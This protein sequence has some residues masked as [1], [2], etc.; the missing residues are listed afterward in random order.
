MDTYSSTF[1]K[2]FVY[3][4]KRR[5]PRTRV[6]ANLVYNEFVSDRHHTHMNATM[7]ESLTQFIKHLGRSG[8]AVVED[9]PKGWYITYK[10]PDA[11]AE[12]EAQLKKAKLDLDDEE[13]NIKF[14][15]KQIGLAKKN[16]HTEE[17]VEKPAE[18]EKEKEKEKQEPP[19]PVKIAFG[20]ENVNK[21]SVKSSSSLVEKPSQAVNALVEFGLD[22]ELT[23]KNKTSKKST[24]EVIM[25]AEEHKKELLNRK[26]YWL[27][28]NIVVKI[29]NSALGDGKYYKKKGLVTKVVDLFV[30]EIQMLEFP[31]IIRLDQSQLETVIPPIGGRVLIVNGAYRGE[32]AS[33][34][35]L[36]VDSFCANLKVDSGLHYGRLLSGIQ[37]EDFS[38]F[39]A[40]T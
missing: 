18:K 36:Q 9:T 4:L 2:D 25:E 26:D 23:I 3:L 37:Y 40:N 33:L 31:D 24:L 15:E 14:I 35:S 11:I 39:A 34:V 27:Y 12:K 22:P 20:F 19:E 38:K 17:V 10:D 6:H 13:R 21:T 5:W 32:T 28:P 8:Q 1:E 30:A 7:W 29:I 16:E